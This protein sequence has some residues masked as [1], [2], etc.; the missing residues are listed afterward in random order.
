MIDIHAEELVPLKKAA[1]LFPNRPHLATLY[2]WMDGVTVKSRR[3]GAGEPTIVQLDTI[4]V[5]AD[6]YTSKEAAQRFVEAYTAARDDKPVAA[7]IRATR[8]R[9]R[10]VKEAKQRLAKAGI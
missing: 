10:D 3:R 8:E 1:K 4:A 5:G 2:R 7:P 6:R 9:Q